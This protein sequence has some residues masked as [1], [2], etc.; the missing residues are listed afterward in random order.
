MCVCAR[1]FSGP[2]RTQQDVKRWG[3]EYEQ[4]IHFALTGDK[5]KTQEVINTNTHTCTSLPFGK[6][7]Q[8]TGQGWLATEL[9]NVKSPTHTH[10]YP[11]MHSYTH[12]HA[13][14]DTHARTETLCR[15][16]LDS[17][18]AGA[19]EL[20]VVRRHGKACVCVSHTKEP[21]NC[22]GFINAAAFQMQ[23]KLS[24][25]RGKKKKNPCSREK[26]CFHT[27]CKITI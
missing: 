11:E 4:M 10:T 3:G 2:G 22:F 26:R 24:G 5:W 8:D 21:L 16:E 20:K 17:E 25:E 19:G 7:S 1:N 23:P 12:T 14:A 15:A 27:G 13:D 6:T 9:T 18:A